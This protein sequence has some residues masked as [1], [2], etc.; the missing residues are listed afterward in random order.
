MNAR[1]V[2]ALVLTL[3]AQAAP[4]Q[5][6]Y[7]CTSAGGGAYL[8]DRPCDTTPRATL[9]AFGPVPEQP[10]YGQ[11]YYGPQMNKAPE[12]L[13]YLSPECAQLNDAVRT[14]PA[15]GLKGASM[16]ELVEDYRRRCG[17]DEQLAHQKLQQAKRDD[18]EQRQQA[19]ASQKAEQARAQLSVDQCNEMLRNLAARR[20]RAAAMTP[21]E[22]G[23][24]ELFEANYKARCK[25]G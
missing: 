12:I 6:M 11:S 7:R 1:C 9:R 2:A 25:A 19:L 14:G 23:D 8:S 15:R 10:S 18:R 13:P 5:A 21:G 17:E 4:G 3:A 16:T 22:R 20:Q 24:L